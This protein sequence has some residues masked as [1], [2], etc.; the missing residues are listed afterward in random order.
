[1]Y[2]FI[3]FLNYFLPPCPLYDTS[4]KS[5]PAKNT[6]KLKVKINPE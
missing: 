1:M 5:I 2:L 4:D 3:G 6:E